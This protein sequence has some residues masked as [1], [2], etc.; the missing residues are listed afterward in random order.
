MDVYVDVKVKNLKR[1]IVFYNKVLGLKILVNAKGWASLRANKSVQIH[2][3]PN[4]GAT[5]G[6]EF[7]VKNVQSFVAGLKKIGVRTS[8]IRKYSWGMIAHFRDSE[9]NA[10][11]I[12]ED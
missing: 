6:L 5:A 4:W 8:G 7:R 3:N 1:A 2:L 11:A 12:V 10:L 9:G